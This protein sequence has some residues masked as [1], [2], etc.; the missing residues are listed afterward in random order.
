MIQTVIEIWTNAKFILNLAA[1]NSKKSM[2]VKHEK[3]FFFRIFFSEFAQLIKI[4]LLHGISRE[5]DCN[6][7]VTLSK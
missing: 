7:A 3:I 6:F 4:I 5:N 1:T 2:R